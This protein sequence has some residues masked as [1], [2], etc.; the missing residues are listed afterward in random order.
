MK[1]KQKI[2]FLKEFKINMK[3]VIHQIRLEHMDNNKQKSL[4]I[5]IIFKG[6]DL[7]LGHSNQVLMY[8]ME[9]WVVLILSKKIN[10]AQVA[11]IIAM[12]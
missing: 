1:N 12:K 9:V 7:V 11:L 3:M 4:D 10:L 5:S 6:M 8:L 2:H